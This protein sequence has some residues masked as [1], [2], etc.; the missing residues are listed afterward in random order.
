M[1]NYHIKVAKGRK[2][3]LYPCEEYT[4]T[5][6]PAEGYYAENPHVIN[7]PEGQRVK[8]DINYIDSQGK[9]ARRVI[10]IPQDG[11]VAYVL[12]PHADGKTIE[13]YPKK[14]DRQANQKLDFRG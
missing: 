10:L 2:A 8:L 9:L 12:D 5:T 4:V 1:A 7:M 11:D 14:R 6:V 3:T 13:T